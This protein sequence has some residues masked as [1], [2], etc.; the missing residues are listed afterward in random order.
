MLLEISPTPP[1]EHTMEN[2]PL[3]LT[4]EDPQ[5]QAY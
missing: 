1:L 4:E 5:I 2:L 3:K